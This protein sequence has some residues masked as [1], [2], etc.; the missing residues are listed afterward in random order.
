MRK[1]T[2]NQRLARR[3]VKALVDHIEGPGGDRDR[4]IMQKLRVIALGILK[5]GK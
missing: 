2:R 4:G 5:E 1:E 3:I